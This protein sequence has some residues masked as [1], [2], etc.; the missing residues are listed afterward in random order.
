MDLLPDICDQFEDKVQLIDVEFKN[1]GGKV[2]FYGEIVTVRCYQDNSLV[3]DVLKTNGQGKVLF[4]DGN[5]SCQKALLGDQ[6]ATLAVQ[7]QWEGVVVFGA[8]RDV[9]AIKMMP[10]GLK[11]LGASP[12]KTEKRGAGEQQVSVTINTQIISP[13]DYI[14][15][16]LN[17][18]LMSKELLI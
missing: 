11:A 2:C 18:V 16:D 17:G 9:G 13:G 1:Y 3:R 8:V 4:I 15:A 14:Y 7:N 10:L 6:V 5:G 12:F